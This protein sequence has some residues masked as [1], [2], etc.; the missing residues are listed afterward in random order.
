MRTP[1]K[2]DIRDKIKKKWFKCICYLDIDLFACILIDIKDILTVCCVLGFNYLTSFPFKLW[3]TC[4][5]YVG[6]STTENRLW[7]YRWKITNRN[8]KGTASSQSKNFQ[9]RERFKVSAM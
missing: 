1:E 6:Q 4:R 9:I 7:K 3:N 5:L 8:S 2:R